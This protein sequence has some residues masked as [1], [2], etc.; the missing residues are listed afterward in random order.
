MSCLEATLHQIFADHPEAE[1][2]FIVSD[3]ASVFSKELMAL[4]VFLT[5][6]KN[7]QW[8]ITDWVNTEAQTG[9]D[10]LDTHFS[11]LNQ[12]MDA[13]IKS[14]EDIAKPRDIYDAF[15]KFPVKSSSVILLE[16]NE[17]WAD[18]FKKQATKGK[19]FGTIKT[20]SRQIHQIL[21]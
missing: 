6:N 2:R 5:S 8:R 15:V 7:T 21:I 19:M 17:S 9:S 10:M 18:M 11:F 12:S 20:P 16:I 3:N 14:G 1:K 4:F 13:F